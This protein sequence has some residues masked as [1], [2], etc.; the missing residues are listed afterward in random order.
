MKPRQMVFPKSV[1]GTSSISLKNKVPTML[2][3]LFFVT[4]QSCQSGQ[5]PPAVQSSVVATT[6][7]VIN[8]PPAAQVAYV[9][10]FGRVAKYQGPFKFGKFNFWKCK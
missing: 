2:A 9:T 6:V 1:S 5:C 10:T 3:E 4:A 7:T 8:G